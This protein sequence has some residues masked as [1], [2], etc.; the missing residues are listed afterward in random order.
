[1]GLPD[2]I[3]ITR[4]KVYK[5]TSYVA[6]GTLASFP[7]E[8]ESV[9]NPTTYALDALLT[10]LA[11]TT[12]DGV[13]INRV[14]EVSDGI[15]ID[16]KAYNLDEGEPTGWTQEVSMT[17]LQTDSDALR[18]VWETSDPVA[19]V[20]S[21][22]NQNRTPLGAPRVFTSRE[23]YV[24]QEDE[25]TGRLRVFAFRDA[26]PQVDSEINIQSEEASGLPVTFKCRADATLADHQGPFGFIFEEDA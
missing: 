18:I 9:I 12:E 2:N 10:P 6:I 5:G 8:L 14:A 3:T 24:I 11:P 26:V 20:G 4:S 17:L 1:M 21:S 7:G 22:V 25:T 16:Q 19:V 15:E 23:L 13:T